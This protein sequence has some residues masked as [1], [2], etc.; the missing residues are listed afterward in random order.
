[1]N[2][3][4]CNFANLLVILILS[5]GLL[6]CAPSE[7]NLKN[8]SL[9]SIRPD[10][11]GNTLHNGRFKETYMSEIGNTP[12]PL[13]RWGFTP[14]PK[15]HLKQQEHY[16]LTVRPVTALPDSKRD[17]LIWLGHATFLMHINGRTL[18]TDPC[19]TAPPLV[20][21]LAQV[22]LPIQTVPLDYVLVSHGHYDHLDKNTLAQL[23]G[24]SLKAL[25]PLK[26]GGLITEANDKITIQEAGWYQQYQ[27]QDDIK[28]TL[29]PAKHW[30]RRS[31]FDFNQTLWG[32][33]LIQW[34]NKSIYFAGDTGYDGHFREIASI[35]G[36]VDYALLPIGAYD[37]PFI[38]QPS[39]LNPEE[40]VQAFKDM[41][42]KNLIP[43]HYGT[44][45]LSDEPLGEPIRWFKDIV[46]QQQLEQVVNI[47]DVGEPVFLD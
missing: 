19:L 25:V 26:I 18:L 27:T 6:G 33:F 42:A 30:N 34:K 21:R 5:A 44:F 13:I 20:K 38:M 47:P 37:P 39:H 24:N 17:Y 31:P 10:F 15:K 46:K 41:G 28:I 11:S 14:N 12:W 36:K 32:S 45:D 7:V 16:A 35:V 8:P 1:M 9:S 4:M 22:P 2:E 43:M 3:L 29:L 40:A 23:Q